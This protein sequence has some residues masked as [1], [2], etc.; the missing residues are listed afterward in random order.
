MVRIIRTITISVVSL[1]LALLLVSCGDENGSC[2]SADGCQTQE[3]CLWVF[4]EGRVIG[5]Q[6]IQTCS[7]DSDC[8][9]GL[10]CSGQAV[11]CTDCKD[12]RRI[13]Q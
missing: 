4:K 6:C 10:E 8:P 2:Q 5:K 13:C 1:C 12:F 11:T 9:S 3:Q 7:T